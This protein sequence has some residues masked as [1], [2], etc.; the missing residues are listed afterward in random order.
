MPLGH[1]WF[2]SAY[3]S[4]RCKY[5]PENFPPKKSSPEPVLHVTYNTSL[6]RFTYFIHADVYCVEVP[7]I[8]FNMEADYSVVLYVHMAR[9]RSQL[10][11]SG[12][13]KFINIIG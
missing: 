6:W 4:A 13:I 7:L 8:R 10:S 12:V 9:A 1:F 5:T 2:E 3:H 11:V